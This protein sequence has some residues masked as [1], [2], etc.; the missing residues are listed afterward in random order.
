[1]EAEK[2]QNTCMTL[3]DNTKWGLLKKQIGSRSRCRQER[4]GLGSPRQGYAV[5]SDSDVLSGKMFL[6]TIQSEPDLCQ[7]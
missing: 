7:A 6:N 4:E 3:H 5:T 1:M 2:R